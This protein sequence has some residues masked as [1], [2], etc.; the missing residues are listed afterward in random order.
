MSRL[1]HI[2]NDCNW[3]LRKRL[4]VK[5]HGVDA[6]RAPGQP[7]R[8][9]SALY[10]C[11]CSACRVN[12]IASFVSARGRLGLHVPVRQ[13]TEKKATALTTRPES[14]FVWDGE[15]Q[16]GDQAWLPRMLVPQSN[17]LTS[18]NHIKM[19]RKTE[20]SGPWYELQNGSKLLVTRVFQIC[21]RRTALS[22]HCRFILAEKG[23]IK[24]QL[25]N[26]KPL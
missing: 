23:A 8:C 2:Q 17:I 9:A 3:D 19:P 18:P 20:V 21:H 6:C 15:T 4:D 11:V 7:P 12:Q 1:P 24:K 25:S 13:F 22:G 10:L 14:A 5:G 26:W 16:G